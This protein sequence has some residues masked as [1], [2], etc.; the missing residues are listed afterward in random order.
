MPPLNARLDRPRRSFQKANTEDFGTHSP[1][2]TDPFETGGVI[3]RN[4]HIEA[5]FAEWMGAVAARA[6]SARP[7]T[8]DGARH[9]PAQGRQRQYGVLK[10]SCRMRA[11]I[12]ERHACGGNRPSITPM[13]SQTGVLTKSAPFT[14][15]AG[16]GVYQ[17]QA[18]MRNLAGGTFT[19]WSPVAMITVN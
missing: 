7:W 8:I 17:F 16:V 11:R 2:V 12:G 9:P 15:N 5:H 1:L 10:F 19:R 18:R 6:R 3:G 14:P 4:L 13:A